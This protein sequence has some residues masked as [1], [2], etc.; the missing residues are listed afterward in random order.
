MVKVAGHLQKSTEVMKMVNDTLK[1]PEIQRTMMEMSK[2]GCSRDRQ[3]RV[4]M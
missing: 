3:G 1:M 2:G 4:L